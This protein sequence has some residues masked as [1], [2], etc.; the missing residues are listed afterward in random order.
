MRSTLG[1]MVTVWIVASGCDARL[2]PVMDPVRNGIALS[3]VAFS[4]EYFVESERMFVPGIRTAGGS[5][6]FSSASLPALKVGSYSHEV[7]FFDKPTCMYVARLG[8]YT[9]PRFLPGPN[10]HRAVPMPGGGRRGG[11]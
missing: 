1:M 8:T 9:G 7:K 2:G 6:L 3:T 5:C 4:S 11:R 10:A